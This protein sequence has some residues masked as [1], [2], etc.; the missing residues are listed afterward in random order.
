MRRM[1]ILSA[2]LSA[3]HALLALCALLAG[4]ESIYGGSQRPNPASCLSDKDCGGTPCDPVLHACVKNRADCSAGAQ[5]CLSA[6]Q[7]ICQEGV[8]VECTA[9]DPCAARDR[10]G[11]DPGKHL[12]YC[13]GAAGCRECTKEAHCQTSHPGYYCDPQFTCQPCTQHEQCKSGICRLDPS[14]LEDPDNRAALGTCVDE[15]EVAVIDS[16]FTLPMPPKIFFRIDCPSC[17]QSA[18]FAGPRVILV[19]SQKVSDPASD[20]RL[21]RKVTFA[22][23]S[24]VTLSRVRIEAA[25]PY[26]D[27]TLGISCEGGST[28]YLRDASISSP[29]GKSYGIRADG[30]SL[31]DL[32]RVYFPSVAGPA[33]WVNNS[34]FRISNMGIDSAGSSLIENGNT[35]V[36]QNSKGSIVFS[37]IPGYARCAG[38]VSIEGSL[39]RSQQMPNYAG[40]FNRSGLC[41][42]DIPFQTGS[43]L[44][45][46]AMR[47]LEWK[48]K[49]EVSSSSELAASTTD[50]FGMPRSLGVK[51]DCGWYEAP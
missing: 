3:R 19:G 29:P 46:S 31:L 2:C 13:A 23:G 50:A 34:S 51:A 7:P 16:G 47:A 45:P 27:A 37:T 42:V 32:D 35:L 11:Y 39:L 17:L 8:C 28:L 49:V 38:S 21:L 20:R 48:D 40:C 30:C 36:I 9:D 12:L 33:V 26:Q 5:F 25:I 10:L 44:I 1:R 18:Q 15:A 43:L 41:P 4:C 22:S 14:L 24:K 6:E